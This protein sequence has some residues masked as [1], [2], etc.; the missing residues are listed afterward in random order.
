MKMHD[1]DIAL[2]REYSLNRRNPE[3]ACTSGIP[4]PILGLAVE[5]VVIEMFG[6]KPDPRFFGMEKCSDPGYDLIIDHE[7]RRQTV[8][9]KLHGI[10]YPRMWDRL[11]TG[12][13]DKNKGK[14]RISADIMVGVKCMKDVSRCEIMGWA[15]REDP[16][17]KCVGLTLLAYPVE[18]L[19]DPRELPWAHQTVTTAR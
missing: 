9:I 13:N 10:D 16:V 11:V 19:R 1:R 6:Q 2:G 5:C 12:F 15:R 3:L 4:S 18:C 8:D 14:S 17:K 7:G